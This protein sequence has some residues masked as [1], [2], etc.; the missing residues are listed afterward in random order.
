MRVPPEPAGGAAQIRR[1]LGTPDI[2]N[3]VVDTIFPIMISGI[4]E[5]IDLQILGSWLQRLWNLRRGSDP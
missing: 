4:L 2:E 5:V 1:G 3:F